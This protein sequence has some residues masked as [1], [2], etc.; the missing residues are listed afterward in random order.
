[1]LYAWS[2]WLLTIILAA[3]FFS[4]SFWYFCKVAAMT[5]LGCPS[6]VRR[7]NLSE[8]SGLGWENLLELLDGIIFH[9]LF[10]SKHQICASAY[11]DE[12]KQLRGTAQD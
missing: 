1:M 2:A 7:K 3:F 11:S 12:Y 9:T 10:W 5:Q 6:F 8:L 4:A